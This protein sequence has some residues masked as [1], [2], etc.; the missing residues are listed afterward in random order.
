MRLL[1]SV[2]VVA[3]VAAA[4]SGCEWVTNASH[5]CSF[6]AAN[7]AMSGNGRYA[8]FR[9]PC[10]TDPVVGGPLN[11]IGVGPRGLDVWQLYLRDL[12]TGVT[13]GI[14]Y[15]TGGGASTNTAI[16]PVVSDDGR[17]VVFESPATDLVAN[18]T[19]G[20]SDVFVRDVVNGTTRR[21][22]ETS[23]GVQGNRFSSFPAIAADGRTVSFVSAA[24]NLVSG[25]SV[26]G[27]IHLADL[28]THDV[29]L[30][31]PAP[32]TADFL[33]GGVSADG[34]H[35]L[36][37]RYHN[38][39]RGLFVRDLTTGTEST[40]VDA[41]RTGGA[42]NGESV[43]PGI[44]A[45]GRYVTWETTAQ[46]VVSGDT[47]ND[48]VFVRDLQTG[49]TRRVSA[50]ITGV[51]THLGAQDPRISRTGRWVAFRATDPAG[52][53]S[54]CYVADLAAAGVIEVGS[55][56]ANGK[57][58]D[59]S[60]DYPSLSGDGRYLAFASAAKNL[61]DNDDGVID[62]YVRFV[63][64][65]VV[66]SAS[67]ASVPRGATTTVTLSGHGFATGTTVAVGG[68]GVT[69]GTPTSIAPTTVTVDVTVAA[70]ATPGPRDVTP[71]NDGTGPGPDRGSTG[72]A[73]SACLT[74]AP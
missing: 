29:T 65:P 40:R 52:G 73:C 44:S 17:Y 48:D 2:V 66:T 61:D 16:N 37:N 11:G 46:D 41:N 7:P 34:K 55:A 63:L 57:P 70:D 64:R 27:G 56:T 39:Q 5:S 62:I 1:R 69:V 31:V 12:R 49:T 3:V 15:A 68:D 19:N 30:P 36:V 8:V 33:R 24:T 67:P 28:V 58:A 21:V 9:A 60:C 18:D 59:A 47:Y 23:T 26:A 10:V 35:M 45:D 53:P 71:T 6:G 50:P 32:T 4:L 13:T 74:V 51:D 72:K 54:Q 38:G 20:W 25:G 43:N 42:P 22:S 14:T